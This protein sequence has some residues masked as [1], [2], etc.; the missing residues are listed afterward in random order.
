VSFRLPDNLTTFQLMAVV[1]HGADGFGADDAQLRVS[2]PLIARP[3]LPRVLRVGDRAMAGVVVH[4]NRDEEREV[5]VTAEATGLTLKGSPVTVTVPAM[6][7]VEVP[8]ALL[9]PVVGTAKL[10]LH[11]RLGP[12]QRRRRALDPRA[13]P[14][15]R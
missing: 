12:R 11:R 2:R 9:D 14:G 10:H 4:N 1:H 13:A 6:G 15:A 7:A 8:F 3:A 5:V